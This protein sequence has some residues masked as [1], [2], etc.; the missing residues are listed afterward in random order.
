MSARIRTNHRLAQM[1]LVLSENI[2]DRANHIR[3]CIRRS[4]LV[5][6]HLLLIFDRRHLVV[7]LLVHLVERNVVLLRVVIGEQPIDQYRFDIVEKT[8]DV[9]LLVELRQF[10]RHV[11][12]RDVLVEREA[13][14]RTRPTRGHPDELRIDLFNIDFI[15]PTHH[16]LIGH[17]GQSFLDALQMSVVLFAELEVHPGHLRIHR[18]PCAGRV[19]RLNGRIERMIGVLVRKI[20]RGRIL[21]TVRYVNARMVESV[22]A[23]VERQTMPCQ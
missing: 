9:E 22:F 8:L 16:V 1:W 5:D 13:A 21:D 14:R 7:A 23:S 6:L 10:V 20:V 2:D 17:D 3:Q 12:S 11:R 15:V 18:A 4:V 19:F